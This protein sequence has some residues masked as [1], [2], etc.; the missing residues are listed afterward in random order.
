MTGDGLKELV[1]V[2]TRGVQVRLDTVY[3]SDN[4]ICVS[5]HHVCGTFRCY[6]QTW[7]LWKK[8]HLKDWSP[9][10]RPFPI[11]P[12]GKGLKI[13]ISYES[14]FCAC[15]NKDVN[16]F[17]AFSSYFFWQK[18]DLLLCFFLSFLRKV[19]KDY[20]TQKITTD[21]MITKDRKTK[22]EKLR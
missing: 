16:D 22:K 10:Y 21:R 13:W 17:W 15:W 18:K 7:L 5:V 14:Q 12:E 1:V 9:L 4:T 8:W 2:T 6:R 3:I 20:Q 19:K 11:F